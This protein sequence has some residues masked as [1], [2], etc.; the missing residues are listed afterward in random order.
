MLL[1]INSENENSHAYLALEE[2]FVQCML[3]FFCMK[4]CLGPVTEV[5]D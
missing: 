5:L 2:N 3:M 1:H 4:S